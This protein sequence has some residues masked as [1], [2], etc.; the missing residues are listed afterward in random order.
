MYFEGQSR[1][2]CE[3]R[4]PYKRE[5]WPLYGEGRRVW[6]LPQPWASCSCCSCEIAWPGGLL[7][8]LQ[9]FFT[10]GSVSELS[11]PRSVG[12]GEQQWLL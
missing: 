8:F 7:V 5:K 3:G 6:V 10:T 2:R 11:F 4:W 1:A 9:G 12:N